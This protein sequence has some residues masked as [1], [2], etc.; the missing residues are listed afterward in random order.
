MICLEPL[1]VAFGKVYGNPPND[2]G[3]LLRIG[4]LVYVPLIDHKREP[5]RPRIIVEGQ[6][7]V[8]LGGVTAC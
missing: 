8:Q 6:L 2:Q 1:G 4:V 3:V 7:S 5:V